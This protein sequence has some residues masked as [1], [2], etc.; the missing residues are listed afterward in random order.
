M[1]AMPAHKVNGGKFEL[2]RTL[3]AVLCAEEPRL[4]LDLNDLILHLLDV[5]HILIHLPLA[6]LY[7]LI[8]LLQSF[9]QILSKYLELKVLFSLN[10]FEDKK[11]RQD[12]IVSD[13]LKGLLKI[14]L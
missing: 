10:N 3:H 2:P 7:H 11:R 8:L 14:C 9:Q 4:R 6:L 1:K 12:F 13:N 5:L